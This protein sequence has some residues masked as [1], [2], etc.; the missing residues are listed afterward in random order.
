MNNGPRQ[1]SYTNDLTDWASPRIVEG[2]AYSWLSLSSPGVWCHRV[3]V[4]SL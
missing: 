1:T 2:S 4:A 3:L